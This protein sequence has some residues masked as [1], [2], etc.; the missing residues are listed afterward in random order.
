MAGSMCVPPKV[1]RAVLT[2][3]AVMVLNLYYRSNA[4]TT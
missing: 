2:H 1:V 4:M 3:L